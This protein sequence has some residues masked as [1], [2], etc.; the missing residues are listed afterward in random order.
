MT[1]FIRG[2]ILLIVTLLSFHTFSQVNVG[3]GLYQN[4][5]NIYARNGNYIPSKLNLNRSS[6]GAT[7]LLSK[8]ISE[9]GWYAELKMDYSI[10]SDTSYL[11]NNQTAEV[12]AISLDQP[13]TDNQIIVPYDYNIASYKTSH[14]QISFTL[15]RKV[16]KYLSIGS[17][18]SVD[19]R[20]SVFTDYRGELNYDWNSSTGNYLFSLDNQIIFNEY[21]V[22]R[23][24]LII[25][26]NFKIHIPIAENELIF[27]NILNLNPNQNPFLQ[28]SLLIKF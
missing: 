23:I 11:T 20:K 28:T 19:I 26:F 24:A 5:G 1:G 17:G 10:I 22:N 3:V 21:E 15:N 25:P 14:Q 27:S 9:E 4:F 12:I 18:L 6:L 16:S 8:V 2:V 7:V 13:K